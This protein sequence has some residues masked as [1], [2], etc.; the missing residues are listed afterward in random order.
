MRLYVAS[1]FENTKAVREAYA[2][3]REDGHE[4]THD[5]TSENAE[6]L[7]GD[8]LEAY[9]SACAEKDAT[10]VL[11]GQ[12]LLL[13]NHK[14]GCGMFSELGIAIAMHILGARI[15]IV[16]IDAFAEGNPHNIFFHLPF[17]HLAKDITEARA[18][19]RAH[20]MTMKATVLE[21]T[22]T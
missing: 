18:I 13:I 7:E 14:R 21:K 5:W 1:K 17:V 16:V 2:A 19:F 9:L 4:I 11:T 3:L 20:E 22:G 12:G 10:G 15:C 8:V 6:G